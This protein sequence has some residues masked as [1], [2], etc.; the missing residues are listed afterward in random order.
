MSDQN[1][2]TSFRTFS[3][4]FAL[5]F[6]S[7]MY[8]HTYIQYIDR[9]RGESRIMLIAQIH[10][11]AQKAVLYF[12]GK[13]SDRSKGKNRGKS[14]SGKGDRSIDTGKGTNRILL[15]PSYQKERWLIWRTQLAY[16]GGRVEANNKRKKAEGRR[17]KANCQLPQK[18]G[19][20]RHFFR[21]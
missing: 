10:L 8:I 20:Y 14:S 21:G 11:I 18:A 3:F 17:Q 16:L 15:S 19:F 1:W 13:G 6:T 2:P 12:R 4:R 7:Y 5:R 9:A